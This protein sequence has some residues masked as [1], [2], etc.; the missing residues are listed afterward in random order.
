[1]TWL[2]NWNYRKPITISNTGSILSNYQVS[3][4]VDTSSLITATKMRSDCGDIRFTD[5]DG[6]SLLYYWIES[7]INTASTKIWVKITSVP[8]GTKTIYMYYGNATPPSDG[9]GSSGDNTFVFFDDFTGTN[10]SS[11]NTTTKWNLTQTGGGIADIQSNMLRTY[12]PTNGN[13]HATSKTTF[14]L[15]IIIE[16]NAQWPGWGNDDAM[17][18]ISGCNIWYGLSGHL[19][20]GNYVCCTGDAS[21]WTGWTGYTTN[22]LYKFR[23]TITSTSLKTEEL[24]NGNSDT[25]AGTYANTTINFGDNAPHTTHTTYVDDIRIRQY[26][27]PE[28]TFSSIGTEELPAII[29]AT[30]MTITPNETPCR[31]NICTVTVNV[32]WTNN[33]GTSDSFVPNLTIDTVPISPAPYTPES[34]VPTASVTKSF[35]ISNLAVGTHSICPYPN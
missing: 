33:G 18:G 30:L 9:Y 23:W 27:S 32:T 8:A 28:P 4:T 13:S 26:A 25:H 6:S 17:A 15:P 21:G 11:P 3:V 16:F 22:T 12:I 7:G 1:M 19:R 35:V 24:V 34:L 20:I 29:T 14:T 31:H 5:N 2:T 10:G